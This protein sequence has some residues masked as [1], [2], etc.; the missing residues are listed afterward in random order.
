MIE[1]EV[2][3]LRS[4]IFRQLFLLVLKGGIVE[5]EGN[6]ATLGVIVK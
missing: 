3:Q 6:L 5:E 4:V 2:M 1:V